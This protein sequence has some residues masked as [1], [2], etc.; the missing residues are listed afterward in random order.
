MRSM[1]TL[2]ITGL[3]ICSL[4]CVTVI[5]AQPDTI[6]GAE[7]TS[8][9]YQTSDAAKVKM[10]IIKLNLL[11]PFFK[12]ISVQYERVI[13]KFLSVTLTARYMPNTTLPY[14]GLIYNM[15]GSTDEAIKD[16]LTGMKMSNFT[17]APEVRFYPGK[18]GFG[19]GFYMAVSYRYSSMKINNLNYIYT[20]YPA[21]DSSVNFSGN[22]NANYGGILLGAQWFLGKHFTLDWWFFGPLVGFESSRVVGVS[23]VLLSQEDQDDLRDYLE[24]DAFPNADKTI[25]VD[26]YG[27]TVDLRGLMYGINFGL[28]LGF[29]F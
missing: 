3:F 9:T 13:L 4:F 11:S 10:N 26:Q 28:A 5:R 8:D 15:S 14:A 2:F 20:N 19:R 25:Y 24:N 29:R 7:S 1:K 17:I 23:N 21:P 22:L 16:A 27:A 18:K 12:N 6:S